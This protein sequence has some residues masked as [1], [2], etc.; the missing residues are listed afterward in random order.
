[1]ILLYDIV[2]FVFAVLMIP[3]LM[4]KGKFHPGFW[5]R[6][7]FLSARALPDCPSG[8]IW[9][10]AV[11][12]GEVLAAQGVIRGLRER[13]PGHPLV[14]TTVTPTGYALARARMAAGDTVLF[15]PL[16]LSWVVRR[17]IRLI[18]PAAYIAAET[19]IWP[20]LF[21]ALK[22]Q[23]VPVL[24]VNG[25]V[26]AKSFSRYRRVRRLLGPALAAVQCFC[27]Q[28][29]TDAE[30]V[31]ALGV[32]A[33]R[34]RVLGNMKFDDLGTT[35]PYARSQ[36][37]LAEGDLVWVAG[38]TH[39]GE[40][41]IVLEIYGRL[42]S[43]FSGLRLI[44]APRHIERADEVEDLIRQA[45]RT[46]VR[47]SR[48]EGQT[49]SGQQVLLVDTIGQLRALYA[50]ADLVFVGKSLTGRGGQNV[51]EPAACGKPILT[52]P[53]MQNFQQIMQIFQSGG[54]I[55][56]VRDRADLEIQ[57]RRLLADPQHRDALGRRARQI[58]LSN[59]GAVEKTLDCLTPILRANILT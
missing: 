9:I 21:A 56:C 16:D 7:G 27:V 12:V 13:W 30:R 35:R 28:T 4:L 55:C 48:R 18:R 52:G 44:L 3:V 50:V 11:S 46:A 58:V 5:A 45:G 17:Y 59:Q 1:M 10:H 40:E 15:A 49:L 53:H 2:F 57:A 29:E 37:G 19:E 14:I 23:G 54:A 33:E 34:V 6:C 43:D 25:R 26:S 38:S 47:F 39:P 24:V 22:G 32:P 42:L 36:L 41:Q 51:I 20:N 31:R 8:R